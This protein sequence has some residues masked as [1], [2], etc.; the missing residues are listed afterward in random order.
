MVFSFPDSNGRH[1]TPPVT[2]L[3]SLYFHA[4]WIGLVPWTRL[5]ALVAPPIPVARQSSRRQTPN[6][7]G[8]HASHSLHAAMVWPV[9]PCH[10]RAFSRCSPVP[11]IYRCGAW[12]GLPTRRVQHLAISPQVPRA[13]ACRAD[14]ASVNKLLI[15]QG[16]LLK[17]GSAIDTT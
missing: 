1:S 9:R 15:Q 12:Q 13:Q 8:M 16:L 17:V 3:A 14:L 7:L 10:K 11:A 2:P 4:R 6:C 5:V